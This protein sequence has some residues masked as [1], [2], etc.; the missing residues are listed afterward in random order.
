MASIEVRGVDGEV[1]GQRELPPELF[2]A[3]L[4]VALMHQVVV[5]GMA[6]QRAGTH[7]TKGR[8]DVRGGGK[9]PWRQKGT[10]RARQGSTRAP[11]WVGGGAAHGPTPHAHDVRVNKKMKK[12]ALR[13]ALSDAARSGKVAIVEGLVFDGP[14]TKDAVHLLEV[15]DVGGRVLLVIE[16]PDEAVERSFRNLAQ[17]RLAYPG[18]LSTY[19]VLFADSVVFTA[20][21]LD[22]LAGLAPVPAPAG[23]GGPS[24]EDD[25]EEEAAG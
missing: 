13:S 11:H 7:S 23:G 21:A 9:K 5:A 16:G 12:A 19:E 4:N 3:P 2:D 17:V 15:L 22:A 25:E 10:G 24:P 14:R 6:A 1:L 8:G 20:P 18:N